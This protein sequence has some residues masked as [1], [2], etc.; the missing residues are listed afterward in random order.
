M[1][2]LPPTSIAIKTHIKRARYATKLVSK[3]LNVIRS[4]VYPLDFGFFADGD[5]ILRGESGRHVI[6]R[7][8]V[9]IP[10]RAEVLKALVW[11]LHVRFPCS[12]GQNGLYLT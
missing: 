4:T 10:I 3:C 8:W 2:N 11:R 9:Q 7:S 1:A 12:Y 6:C 5:E